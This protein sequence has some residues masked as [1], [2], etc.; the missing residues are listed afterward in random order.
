MK[1]KKKIVFISLALLLFGTGIYFPFFYDRTVAEIGDYTI[2]MKQVE[3]RDQIHHIFYPQDPKSYGK[4][5]LVNAYIY[6]QILKNNGQEISER[7]LREEEMRIDQN[8]KAPETLK[9]I[10]DLFRGDDEAYRNV[11]VLPTYAERVIYFDFFTKNQKTQEKSLRLVQQFLSDVVKKQH[12]FE[13]VALAQNLNVRKFLIS[14]DGAIDWQFGEKKQREQGPKLIDQSGKAAPADVQ[15]QV[16]MEL[17]GKS[18]LS[19]K[20]WV[21]NVVS[22]MRAGDVF[23]EPVD[24]GEHWMVTR[25]LKK[26][27]RGYI[28]EAAFIPKDSY[29][30]WLAEEK[31]KIKIDL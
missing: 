28:M 12:A 23:P 29:E 5:Q 24:N 27:G 7:V 2:T 19:V 10:R 9:A 13:K 6:A 20:S 3:Y 18:M 17:E 25:L 16:Q 26:Q 14:E 1:N 8:T 21:E 11:F 22:H 31:A 30:N 15:K 4:E